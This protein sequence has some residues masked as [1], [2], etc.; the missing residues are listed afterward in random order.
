MSSTYWRGRPSVGSSLARNKPI[1]SHL[2][3][4]LSWTDRGS[5]LSCGPT[6]S[7]PVF[8]ISEVPPSGGDAPGLPAVPSRGGDPPGPPA[9]STVVICFLALYSGGRWHPVEL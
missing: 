3:S 4:H 5:H 6:T 2:A 7:A 9:F 1:R 8:S